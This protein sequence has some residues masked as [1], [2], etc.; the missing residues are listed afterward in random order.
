MKSVFVRLL[1]V[2]L[3]VPVAANAAASEPM[4]FT[5]F[6]TDGTSLVSFGENGYLEATGRILDAARKIRQGI[7]RLA[8]LSVLG[9]PLWVIAFTTKSV[10][11]Y[12][13]LDA[14]HDRGWNLNGLQHPPSIHLCVTLTHTQP[15]VAE[16]FLADLSACV[17][18]VKNGNPR[19]GGLAPIYGLS[20]SF[21]VRGAVK[22]LLRRYV[23]KLYEP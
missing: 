13:V 12:R 3:A 20:G 11:V 23:D 15:G 2:S 19:P 14:L 1:V 21:P 18:Q 5:L 16:R 8:E 4:L 22:D 9:D 6:L 17:E 10:D 7:E